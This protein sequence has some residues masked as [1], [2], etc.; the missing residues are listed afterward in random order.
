MTSKF[1]KGFSLVELLVVIAIIGI[2]AAVG[3]TAYSGYTADAKVKASTSQHSQV[4][5]LINAEMARC[6]SGKGKFVWATNGSDDCNAA[7]RTSSIVTYFSLDGDVPL[8]N[9]YK[10]DEP[11]VDTELGAEGTGTE[12]TVAGLTEEV[13]ELGRIAIW[14][15]A[16]AVTG[17]QICIVR[18]ETGELEPEGDLIKTVKVY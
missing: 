17:D 12:L 8:K 3:I 14:C 2:L 5:A 6:A 13:T 10:D 9:P 1:Q 18:S 7:V 11:S 16:Q 15:G 4:V